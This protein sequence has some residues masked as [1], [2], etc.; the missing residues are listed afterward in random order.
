MKLKD[1]HSEKYK[2]DI[3]NG[4]EC[5]D[6]NGFE[7]KSTYL[8]EKKTFHITLVPEEKNDNLQMLQYRGILE[9][10]INR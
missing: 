4:V 2:E 9:Y 8:M 7:R 1:W 10:D 5:C 6:A 3:N